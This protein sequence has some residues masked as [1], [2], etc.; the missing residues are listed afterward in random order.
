MTS[1]EKS[2]YTEVLQ[3]YN[4][5]NLNDCSPSFGLI[6]I[7][8]LVKAI[9]PKK[10]HGLNFVSSQRAGSNF[11]FLIEDK[12]FRCHIDDFS[13]EEELS[14][15]YKRLQER[16]L[17]KKFLSGGTQ[18]NQSTSVN[19]ISNLRETIFE[20][21]YKNMKSIKSPLTGKTIQRRSF[22]T[23]NN[24]NFAEIKCSKSNLFEADVSTIHCSKFGSEYFWGS[25]DYMILKTI[26]DHDDINENQ[27][28]MTP[29]AK[30]FQP[31]TCSCCEI[32]V[33][34][35]DEF[36][37]YSIKLLIEQQCLN[38]ECT[39]DVEKA[40]VIIKTEN[41]CCQGVKVVGIGVKPKTKKSFEQYE[42]FITCFKNNSK[43]GLIALVAGNI[44]PKKANYI[45][46]AGFSA[47]LSKPIFLSMISNCF[48]K[49]INTTDKEDF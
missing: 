23:N 10:S 2:Q 22:N 41:T 30:C 17:D 13:D 25:S 19:K 49:Y 32:V 35:D 9:S 24:H 5:S 11:N 33:V 27:S 4:F 7:N 38:I 18:I 8:Y 26:V 37:N 47:Y 40:M 20:S 28:K 34:D 15:N 43:I 31:K 45:K 21:T 16:T 46:N 1:D 6:L 29:K 12:S 36:S 42:K 48:L 14:V 44:S 39:S 3:N